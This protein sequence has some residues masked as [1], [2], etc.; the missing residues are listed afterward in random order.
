MTADPRAEALRRASR[1]V[2]ADP[3][4]PSDRGTRI[5]SPEETLERLT[6]DGWSLIG[7]EQQAALADGLALA[8][9]SPPYGVQALPTVGAVEERF[10][11]YLRDE[12]GGLLVSRDGPTIA[13][14]ADAARGALP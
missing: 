10:T 7:P 1:S 13:A 14:A 3:D 11:I 2:V 8:R 4:D 6:A 9:L 5:H 12:E